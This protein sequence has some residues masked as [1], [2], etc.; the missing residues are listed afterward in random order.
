MPGDLI[1]N[2][3]IEYLR[4]LFSDGGKNIIARL[5]GR[6][7]LTYQPNFPSGLLDSLE[8]ELPEGICSGDEEGDLV[9]VYCVNGV[10]SLR[11]QHFSLMLDSGQPLTFTESSE[12]SQRYWEAFYL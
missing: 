12:K 6:D 9:R 3:G 4:E 7:I 2:I 8:S 11:Y 10:L 5:I 1:F